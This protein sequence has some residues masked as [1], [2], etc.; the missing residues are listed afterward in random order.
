[1]RMFFSQY[2]GVTEAG[3][4]EGRNILW[5]KEPLEKFAKEKEMDKGVLQ[6]LLER[7]R[8]KLMIARASRIRPGLDDKI[9]LG[10]NALM[11]TAT[12]KAFAATGNEEYRQLAV[13]NMRFLLENLK[14]GDTPGFHHTWKKGQ[15]KYPAFLDDYAYLVQSL[16]HLQE[17]TGDS[18]WLLRAETLTKHV[19]E[20]FIEEDS[21]FFYYTSREQGDIILRKKELYDGAIPSGNAIMA[22]NLYH[23]AI[24]LDRPEWMEHCRGMVGAIGNTVVKYPTSFGAW[25]CLLQEMIVGTNEIVVMGKDPDAVQMELLKQ[26]IPH[27]VLM[28][29]KQAS[30]W[31]LLSGKSLADKTN[32]WLCRNYSCHPPVYS[33]PELISL[34]NREEAA[35]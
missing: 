17:I 19:I 25:G 5:I 9:I 4:W 6:A 10:W 18:E 26:Y 12:S 2:Y 33:V 7:G 14:D 3:N 13:R 28:V 32:I 22:Q 27:R 20:Q 8:K 30:N 34:I 31:P 21:G 23:L 24:L 15:A 35:N 1:M 11:N 16:L 29:S